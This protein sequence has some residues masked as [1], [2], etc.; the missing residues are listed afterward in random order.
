MSTAKTVTL[1]PA[2]KA[3]IEKRV[4]ANKPKGAKN[5]TISD[6]EFKIEEAKFR[7]EMQT[8]QPKGPK[9]IVDV[10][11]AIDP[12]QQARELEKIKQLE[13]LKKRKAENPEKLKN[14]R[15][16]KKEEEQKA[17]ASP[18][19]SKIIEEVAIV[20]TVVPK[21]NVESVSVIDDLHS[22]DQFR[23]AEDPYDGKS[24]SEVLKAKRAALEA[25]LSKNAQVKPTD[26]DSVEGR[27]RRLQAQRDALI[28]KRKAE[29]DQEL[30]D[31]NKSKS[32]AALDIARNSFYAQM[33]KMD[34]ALMPEKKREVFDPLAKKPGQPASG[35]DKQSA[36][37]SD[38]VFDL[39]KV[40]PVKLK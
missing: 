6:A 12:A 28:A 22:G 34:N 8:T 17:A 35:S 25:E 13:A 33:I 24:F 7:A 1:T 39:D 23:Q 31:Y 21:P 2:Q 4:L 15:D 18:K 11:A 14:I 19:E 20:Q 26:D 5:V 37:M 16:R 40:Q 29:R 38:D 36:Q 10:K 3:E 27:K 32:G 30:A 9:E